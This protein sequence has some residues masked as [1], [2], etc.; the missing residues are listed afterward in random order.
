LSRRLFGETTPQYKEGEIRISKHE[1]RNKFEMQMFQIRNIQREG[2]CLGHLE[3]RILVLVS[4]FDIRISD[5]RLCRVRV[6]GDQ[7]RILGQAVVRAKGNNLAPPAL[8]FS[9]F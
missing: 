7:S 4:D 6:C 3:I 2:T 9:S 5:F 8:F 1:I